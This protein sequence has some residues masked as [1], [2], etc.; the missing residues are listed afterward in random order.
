[1]RREL[2]RLAYASRRDGCR[3]LYLQLRWNGWLVNKKRV[4]RLYR[5][6]KLIL[7]RKS[8][9]KLPEHLRTAIPAPERQDECWS[10]DFLSDAERT[11]RHIRIL[12]LIDDATREN[13]LLHAAHSMTGK[14]VADAVDRVATFRGY[15]KFL[16]SDNGPEF[17]SAAFAAW[18]AKNGVTLVFIEPGKPHQNCFIESFNGKFR[19][20]CL[21]LHVFE[22]LRYAQEV[23]DTYRH[24]Y[25]HEKPHGSL[26]V[27]PAVFARQLRK[28]LEVN[29]RT[30]TQSVANSGG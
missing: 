4:E 29:P 30:K 27:P 11:G 18:A 24:E 3:A 14:Q 6:E 2:K 22:S 7:R 12:A 15:P 21:D 25:N 5:E 8:K 17:R 16:R 28:K 19:A 13:L 20:K 1:L 23:I 9:K 10:I 26:G